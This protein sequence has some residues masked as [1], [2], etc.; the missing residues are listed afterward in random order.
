M[1]RVK[2]YRRMARGGSLLFERQGPITPIDDKHVIEEWTSAAGT[3]YFVPRYWNAQGRKWS[4]YKD[5]DEA[6]AYAPKTG[7]MTAR[8][9][10]YQSALGVILQSTLMRRKR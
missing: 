4:D 2:R 3:L 6:I 5:G 8:T 9:M 10:A 1:T 7:D